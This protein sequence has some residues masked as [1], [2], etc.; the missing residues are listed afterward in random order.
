MGQILSESGGGGGNER[1]KF[2]QLVGPLLAK[3]GF[4]DNADHSAPIGEIASLLKGSEL[5][6]L[7][8]AGFELKLGA[9]DAHKKSEKQPQH[10]NFADFAGFI[11]A[12][13]SWKT[14]SFFF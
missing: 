13:A 14:F 7:I 8:P 11:Y 12:V 3:H 1:I 4:V 5:L 10:C 9:E 2:A 6:E